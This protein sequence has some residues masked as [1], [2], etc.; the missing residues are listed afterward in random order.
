[1]DDKWRDIKNEYDLAKI[2]LWPRKGV[3]N[4]GRDEDN[5][6]YHLWNAYHMAQ[7]AD[8]KEDLIYAR[9][10][11]TMATE[12][13][14][15]ISEFNKY[16]KFVKPSLDAYRRAEK[17]GLHPS[18][19]E[20]DLITSIAESLD[21]KL[22]CEEAP[23]EEMLKHIE[24]YEKLGDFRFH[25]SKSIH[26]EHDEHSAKLTLQFGVIVEFKF[27]GVLS[28]ETH[29]DPAYDYIYDF[30]CYPCLH[31]KKLLNFDVDFYKIICSSIAVE[32]ISEC[33]S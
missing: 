7:E 20:L 12:S 10:L 16:N 32:S 19:K 3:G 30:Y 25:D 33:V 28:I 18:D 17:A 11:A 29:G 2:A 4:W 23:Y 21:Y 8:E 26:F 24:G 13:C 5:G 31:D 6:L 1:M 22:N 15:C 27:D 14:P 9:I